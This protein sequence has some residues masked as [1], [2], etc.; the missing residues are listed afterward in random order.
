MM[1]S[2]GLEES[3]LNTFDNGSDHTIYKE[4]KLVKWKASSNLRSVALACFLFFK[5]FLIKGSCRT[6]MHL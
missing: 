5:L 2:G 1:E 6:V 3:F 4:V